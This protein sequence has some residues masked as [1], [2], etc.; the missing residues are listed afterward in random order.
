MKFC[1]AVQEGCGYKDTLCMHRYFAP[2]AKYFTVCITYQPPIVFYLETALHV[3]G[4]TI[5]H[6]QERKQLYLQHLVFVTSLLLS[7]T[8]LSVL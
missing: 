8:G 3:S 4:G 2:L 1:T 6:L 5:T 7:A